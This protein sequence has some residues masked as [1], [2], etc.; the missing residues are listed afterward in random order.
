MSQNTRI[1]TQDEL[2]KIVIDQLHRSTLNLSSQ[3]F[4]TKKLCVITLTALVTIFLGL[5][6]N[7]YIIW[8]PVMIS[9]ITLFFFIIDVSL[10]YYQVSLSVL[11]AKEENKIYS[12]NTISPVPDRTKK[13]QHP[14]RKA[15]FNP[16]QIFYWILIIA[17]ILFLCLYLCLS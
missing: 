10:Y 15:I 2:S 5:K 8:V 7:E 9:V 13:Y 1:Q 14:L 6:N 17:P 11:M 3:C 4:E 12:R 16:S